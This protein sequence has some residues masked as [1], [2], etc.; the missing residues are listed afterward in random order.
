MASST[1]NLCSTLFLIVQSS[2]SAA[3]IAIT[4]VA[5]TVGST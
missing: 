4:N 3:A 5:V 1:G 2:R